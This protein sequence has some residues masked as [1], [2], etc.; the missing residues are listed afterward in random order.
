MPNGGVLIFKIKDSIA[1]INLE[2]LIFLKPQ[3]NINFEI[4]SDS[5]TYSPGDRVEFDIR[6]P[7][8]DEDEK[9]YASI[10]VTDTSSFL[11]VPK[12][13]A[14]PSLPAMVYLEKEIKSQ[15]LDEF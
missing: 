10:V 13:K 7:P 12:Y 6:I 3:S 15:H 8:S 4:L 5:S 9:F 11:K 1:K 14:M 2:R